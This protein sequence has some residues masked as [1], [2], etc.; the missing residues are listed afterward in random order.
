MHTCS[1]QLVSGSL[2][3]CPSWMVLAG[4]NIQI[5]AAAVYLQL[6]AEAFMLW[7]CAVCANMLSEVM[8]LS[9]AWAG[10]TAWLLQTCRHVNGLWLIRLACNMLLCM[11]MHAGCIVTVHMTNGMSCCCRYV[12]G[13][14]AVPLLWL[15]PHT[16]S[17]SFCIS[18]L[19]EHCHHS[20]KVCW[21]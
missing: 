18:I 15:Q 20:V 8:Y 6:V 16:P 9:P 5:C 3:D 4:E 10:H 7:Q 21:P 2:C 19:T 17:C 14:T 12:E 13:G 11:Q 1:V